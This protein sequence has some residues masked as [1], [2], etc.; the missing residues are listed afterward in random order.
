MDR[1][2]SGCL[3]AALPYSLVTTNLSI[4][5]AKVEPLPGP[6]D[7]QRAPA[8]LGPDPQHGAHGARTAGA[9]IPLACVCFVMKI[10]LTCTCYACVTLLA[11]QRQQNLFRVLDSPCRRAP[12]LA[13]ATF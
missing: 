4:S 9:Y 11:I 8:D 2:K 7:K 5:G 13:V 10:M 1:I 3:A 12:A 6:P